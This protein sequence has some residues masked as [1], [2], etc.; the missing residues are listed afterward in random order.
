MWWLAWLACRMPA[1]VVE[2]SDSA[3]PCA[4]GSISARPSATDPLAIVVRGTAGR[5]G[6]ADLQW[7]STVGS[8]GA[9]AVALRASDPFAVPLRDL[10]AGVPV[11][12]AL[13]LDG[14]S[15]ELLVERPALPLSWPE[16]VLEVSDDVARTGLWCLDTPT[17]L[18]ERWS[19][20]DRSARPVRTLQ[21]LDGAALPMVRPLASDGLVG[22][23]LPGRLTLFDALG[24]E[25][26]RWTVDALPTRFD[27]EFFDRHDV[28]ELTQG[29]WTG[30]LAVLTT[31]REEVAGVLTQANG[32]VVLDPNTGD[33]LWDW[34]LHG[35]AGD[36]RTIDPA[37]LSY[38]R[39]GSAELPSTDWAHGNALLHG[40]DPYDGDVF[41]LSLR[42][43]DWI[44]RVD[45]VSDAITW[46]LGR[47]GDFTLVDAAGVP[48]PE[49][50]WFNH[51]HAPVWVGG[52][53]DRVVLFDNGN[54]RA[55]DPADPDA[56]PY[57]RAIELEL[58]EQ[59]MTATLVW[60]WG[61][62][63][64]EHPDHFYSPSQGSAV[65]LDDGAVG[66]LWYDGGP[67]IS[68]VE[69]D[70]TTRWRAHWSGLAPAYRAGWLE[71]LYPS[72]DGL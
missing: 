46:R 30:A 44:V 53:P 45:V 47:G 59:S 38:E 48:L 43:L 57:S 22:V 54:Y 56:P 42:S 33:V 70:G 29:A 72:T 55:V 52:D 4:L 6:S 63:N 67:V 20:V 27:H 35:E 10:P 51:Q 65:P 50:Q 36:D 12:V 17:G 28:I 23:A 69:R 41:W 24:D 21:D 49:H 14:S 9:P 8:G 32:I 40:L 62:P 1:P 60:S 16:A 18:V 68:E 7:T 5:S 34:S 39:M 13:T 3:E 19:C 15:C 26:A 64:P 61:S 66:V 11:T 58:D 25:R 2:S 71:G 31:T 37:A